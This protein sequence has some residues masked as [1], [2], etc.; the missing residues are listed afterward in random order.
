MRS[1]CCRSGLLESEQI[2]L[3]GLGSKIEAPM[4]LL[5][6]QRDVPRKRSAVIRWG[7][8]PWGDGGVAGPRG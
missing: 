7:W 1:G 5:D 8:G 6:S 4:G 2:L 3:V